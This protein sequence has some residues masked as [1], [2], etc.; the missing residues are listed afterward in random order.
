MKILADAVGSCGQPAPSS[1]ATLT[2]RDQQAAE[3][4]ISAARSL[5]AYFSRGRQDEGKK[6]FFMQG[7]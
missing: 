7:A 2:Q 1:L 3:K 5:T 6:P 4:G